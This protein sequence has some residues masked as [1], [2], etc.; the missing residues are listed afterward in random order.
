[1]DTAKDRLR[2]GHRAQILMPQVDDWARANELDRYL[3][4]IETAIDA[5]TA[6]EE[7]SAARQWLEW[8]RDYIEAAMHRST[9]TA[10]PAGPLPIGLCS[11]WVS[12]RRE[13]TRACSL[14]ARSSAPSATGREL[15]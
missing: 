11:R 2:E 8:A 15:N 10:S 14:V 4:A 3:K 1:M 9:T 6:P 5:M 12:T 13:S 7:R